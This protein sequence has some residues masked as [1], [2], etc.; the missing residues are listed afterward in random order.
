MFRLSACF[1]WISEFT[2]AA[3]HFGS[4]SMIPRTNDWKSNSSSSVVYRELAIGELALTVSSD[5]QDSVSSS[6]SIRGRSM[7]DSAKLICRNTFFQKLSS[8]LRAA[9][10]S[11]SICLRSAIFLNVEI[12]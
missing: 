2:I 6:S 9:M 1:R 7:T 10:S 5:E 12:L 8:R 4:L 3:A 11:S